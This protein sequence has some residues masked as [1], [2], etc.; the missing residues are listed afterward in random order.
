[1]QN[2]A[3]RWRARIAASVAILA[4]FPALASEIY[5]HR[6]AEGR[7]IFSDNAAGPPGTVESTR[8]SGVGNRLL[9]LAPGSPTGSPADR[10]RAQADVRFAE[11]ELMRAYS[12][13]TTQVLPRPHELRPREATDP[14]PPARGRA[15][16]AVKKPE[17][18]E[19]IGALTAELD[20]AQRRLDA[21][22]ERFYALD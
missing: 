22:R 3:V 2:S 1:L 12:R 15:A 16:R 14:P 10:D 4:C 17:Y 7:T 20:D 8:V 18:Y 5:R 6:T 9:A 21:A 13:L 11:Q 19:R